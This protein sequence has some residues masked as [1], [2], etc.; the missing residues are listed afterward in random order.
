MSIDVVKNAPKTPAREASIQSMEL[1][2]AGDGEGWLSL[3]ADDADGRSNGHL[4]TDSGNLLQEHTLVKR[5]QFHGCLVGFDFGN[6]VAGLYGVAFIL[7]PVSDGSH[8]H[9]VAKFGHVDYSGH[10]LS[11]IICGDFIGSADL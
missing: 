9:G 8:C 1:S 10:I 5:F 2:M 7:E 3:F 4:G 6:D 11:E